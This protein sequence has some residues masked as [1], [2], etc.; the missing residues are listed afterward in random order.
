MEMPPAA[1][2]PPMV[3]G[4]VSHAAAR[5][6]A[7]SGRAS[8]AWGRCLHGADCIR[9]AGATTA[10]TI[11]RL[12]SSCWPKSG[13]TCLVPCGSRRSRTK[14]ARDRTRARRPA[15]RSR[16]GCGIGRRGPN[17]P[18]GRALFLIHSRTASESVASSRARRA[19]WRRRRTARPCISRFV[20]T[21]RRRRQLL[22]WWSRDRP[23]S[24]RPNRSSWAGFM[25]TKQGVQSVGSKQTD[26][27]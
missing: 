13:A 21:A 19:K 24:N 7:G 12:A 6:P 26:G 8:A 2:P 18:E 3:R 16:Q 23:G 4:P 5:P 10:R 15:T 11:G 1:Q 14:S 22:A 9:A 17:A 20:R 27:R 25:S